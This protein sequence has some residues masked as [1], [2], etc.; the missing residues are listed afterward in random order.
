MATFNDLSE[1]TGTLIVIIGFVVTLCITLLG[2][3]YKIVFRIGEALKVDILNMIKDLD[4][5]LGDVW[6]EIG[7]IRE[8]QID[9]RQELPK[10]YLRI[11]GP[12]YKA[13][14]DGIIRIEAHF[15]A[16]A[17]ECRSGKCGGKK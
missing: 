17:D 3:I 7:K 12:G 16:F 13:L 11:E 10:A 5:K 9:L 2:V 15:E 4:N 8:R 14:F 1:H 6:K